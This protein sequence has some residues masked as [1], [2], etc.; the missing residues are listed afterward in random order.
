MLPNLEEH[1]GPVA[2]PALRT[3]RSARSMPGRGTI[4]RLGRASPESVAVGTP[5][6]SAAPSRRA[7]WAAVDRLVDSTD[8]VSALRVNGLHLFAARRWREHG[9]AVPAELERAERLALLVT[10]I[11]PHVLR[12]VRSACEGT[13]VLHKGPEIAARYPDPALR[14][15]I[16]LDVLVRDAGETQQALLGAGFEEVG[17]PVRYEA[18][19]HLRP[20]HMPGLPLLV[21]VHS[22]PNWPAWLGPPPVQELLDAAV[23][24]SL[25]IDGVLT[26]APHH[27]AL[28]V[29]A[30]SWAHGPLARVRD[31]VDV[32]AMAE[33]LERAELLSTARRWGLERLWRTTI[34]TAGAVLFGDSNPYADSKPWALRTW[35]RNLPA[36]RERTVLERH[37]ALLLAGF[38]ALGVGRGAREMVAQAGRDLRPVGDEAWG[39]K[40]WRTRVALR[41]ARVRKSVHEEELARGARRR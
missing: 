37:V 31:L 41:N 13:I 9:R 6:S 23:P 39:T 24:S 3:G 17:D 5:L 29:A 14:S 18:T 34:G 20:L 25:G 15:Y 22:S 27:H 2:R 16:D 7:L 35:A 40:L 19:P 28:A 30:H 26:L 38:S 1:K 8:D 21:E 36:V 32:A 4:P 33:G 12:Q 10:L 11:V